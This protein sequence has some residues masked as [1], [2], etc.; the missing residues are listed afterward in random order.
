M[1]SE[2]EGGVSRADPACAAPRVGVS[3]FHLPH[4]R[5]AN[6][7]GGSAGT[8][9]DTAAQL[10][11]RAGDSR[12][13][14]PID[15]GGMPDGGSGAVSVVG[16]RWLVRGVGGAS[17]V[18][19]GHGGLRKSAS[20]GALSSS[21]ES[22][23]QCPAPPTPL[24]ELAYAVA[25]LPD[26]WGL[27]TRVITLRDRLTVLNRG[28]RPLRLK[29]LGDVDGSAGTLDPGERRPVHWRS[30]DLK[31][32]LVLSFHDDDDNGDDR[33]GNGC[34]DDSGDGSGGGGGC[35]D[36]SDGKRVAKPKRSWQWSGAVDPTQICT[37]SLCVR[38]RPAA[39]E[40]R[41]V[42]VFNSQLPARRGGSGGVMAGYRTLR[43]RVAL[44]ANEEGDAGAGALVMTVREE[45]SATEPPPPKPKPNATARAAESGAAA[46][47]AQRTTVGADPRPA[48][49]VRLENR[50]GWAVYHAQ[51]GLPLGRHPHALTHAFSLSGSSAPSPASSAAALPCDVLL[52][53]E[54]GAPFGWDLP[55]PPPSRAHEVLALRLSLAPLPGDGEGGIAAAVGLRAGPEAILRLAIG[56]AETLPSVRV[57]ASTGEQRWLGPAV[58]AVFTEGASTVLRILRPDSPHLVSLA[59]AMSFAAPAPVST[60]LVTAG[61]AAGRRRGAL[62]RKALQPP[63]ESALASAAALGAM[64]TS[65][66]GAARSVRLMIDVQSLR[67]SLIVHGPD[68][69]SPLARAAAGGGSSGGSSGQRGRGEGAVA[70]RGG[71]DYVPREVLVGSLETLRLDAQVSEPS[72][73]A[74]VA[75]LVGSAQVDNHLPNSPYP[76]L[77]VGN[78]E[79]DHAALGRPGRGGGGGGGDDKAPLLSFCVGLVPRGPCLT[80]VQHLALTVNGRSHIMVDEGVL[81]AAASLMQRLADRSSLAGL[82]SGTGGDSGPEAAAWPL[83]P[84]ALLVLPP[85]TRLRGGSSKET[86]DAT[87]DDNEGGSDDDSEDEATSLFLERAVVHPVRLSLSVQRPRETV[88]DVYVGLKV[89]RL[90][91]DL[92]VRVERAHLKLDTLVLADAT[93]T[94]RDLRAAVAGH[95]DRSVRRQL[96]S[97][98]GSLTALGNPVGL[99]RGLAQGVNDAVNAPLEG[100]VRAAETSNLTELSR[101]IARGASSFAQHTVRR[102]GGSSGPED[103]VF[104]LPRKERDI[105]RERERG[106][107]YVFIPS[108][109]FCL[110]KTRAAGGRCRKQR[111]ANHVHPGDRGVGTGNG[112]G[113]QAAAGG[114]PCGGRQ[115]APRLLRWARHGGQQ[116]RARRRRRCGRARGRARG[117]V[118]CGGARGGSAGGRPRCRRARGQAARGAQ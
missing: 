76:V 116:R 45:A 110:G 88:E 93:L 52:P 66:P 26:P 105:Y 86:G 113:V 103:C 14:E 83:P 36:G 112:Q 97:A 61:S 28:P 13:S 90:A 58:A 69:T 94:P 5:V 11:V 49:L 114:A 41:S 107:V 60:A 18:H 22:R 100:L 75:V 77:F 87:D 96:F 1:A 47:S 35:D 81:A 21:A 20:G 84:T 30:L 8:R 91:L 102:L 51:R 32:L 2:D 109:L 56:A 37:F 17:S 43:V 99:V 9:R 57:M 31:Q 79:L 59:R 104:I 98:L 48:P 85:A 54:Q 73:V 111:G 19:D 40:D 25:P 80:H 38:A 95:Y 68:Q 23:E 118:R 53:D 64:H 55:C 6:G 63:A 65:Q 74:T 10:V 71:R 7:S 15:V 115:T 33:Y 70:G 72:G 12:W 34:N 29:Q 89:R 46:S 92:L 67:A 42:A 117:W 4:V 27:R 62:L 44:A 39:G 82:A 24:Y 50:T 101:G 78:P 108:P 16:G 106:C 3:L